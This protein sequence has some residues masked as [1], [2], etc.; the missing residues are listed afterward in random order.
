VTIPSAASGVE[1]GG[2]AVRMDGKVI[3]LSK[4]IE[5]DYLT[6]EEILRRLMEAI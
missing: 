3:V 5:N 6:D 2:T 4:I 1:S